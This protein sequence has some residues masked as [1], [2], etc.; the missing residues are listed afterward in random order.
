MGTRG[1]IGFRIDGQDKV[2]YNHFDSYPNGL[3]CTVIETVRTWGDDDLGGA[4]RRVIMVDAD[5]KPSPLEM[6]RYFPLANLGVST[7]S[8]TEW[9]CL[10]RE[11]QGELAPYIDGTVDHMIDSR[12]FLGDSLF[13]EWAYIV[14]MD[15]RTVEVYQGFNKNPQAPG[16]YANAPVDS[17]GYC[18]VA[19]IATLPL[20]F[21][22]ELD[23]DGVNKVLAILSANER[24]DD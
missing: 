22:R 24:E 13:C 9:Y 8:V 3:G 12:G 1:A 5:S 21:L 17:M 7:G 19:L 16:R 15:E 10:L 2:T 14:N 4:A 6:S 20:D 11:I 18:G 23:D